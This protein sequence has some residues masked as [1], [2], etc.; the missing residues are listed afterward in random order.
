MQKLAKLY[1]DFCGLIRICG[2]LFALRWMFYVTSSFFAILKSGNLQ[3]PDSA[4]GDGPFKVTLKQYK[5]HFKIKGPRC[6][7]GIREMYVRDV[8]LGNGWLNVKANDVV[9]DLGANMG[10]F[11]NLALA[12]DPTVRVIAIEPSISL[13]TIFTKSVDLNIG[14]LNRTTLIRAILGDSTKRIEDDDNYAGADR[15]TEKQLLERANITRIDFI[16][17][18]IE[19][20]EFK[21]LN[22]G[23]K[24]LAMTRALACEVHVDAGDVSRFLAD[25]EACGLTVGPTRYAEDG[26]V[27]FLARRSA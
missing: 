24:L 8:Y 27:I 3:L 19:G 13:N 12:I 14:H 10:N 23:S 16:K 11:T 25:V 17:C 9:L 18:D 26:S 1:K 7:S 22:R 21:F 4:M 5:C 6:V 20:G 2:P 15:L